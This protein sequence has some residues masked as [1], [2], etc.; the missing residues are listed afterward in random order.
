MAQLVLAP[1]A[2]NGAHICLDP[3]GLG[4]VSRLRELDLTPCFEHLASSALLFV[5]CLFAGVRIIQLSKREK[6]IDTG[7]GRKLLRGKLVGVVPLV[8]LACASLVL[9]LVRHWPIATSALLLHASVTFVAY[10]LLGFLTH[11]NHTRTRRSSTILLTLW[12]LHLLEQLVALRTQVLLGLSHDALFGIHCAL[13]GAGIISW[14]LECFCP[15]RAKQDLDAEPEEKELPY[16][17][18]NVYSR[19]TFGWMTPLMKLGYSRYI[20]EKD[21][22]SLSPDDTARALSDKL[23]QHWSQQLH[24]RNPSLWAALLRAYGGSYSIAAL[25]KIVRDVLSFTEPQLLR[26]FL[27]FIAQYQAGQVQSA[28]R[29]WAIATAM[30]VV[31]VTQTAMLH[32]YFQICFVTGMRV[33]AGLV[34]AI[35][36]KALAQAPDSQGARGDVVNLMSVDATRLQDLCTY[37]LIA[38]S[39]PLQIV[40]AFISLYNLLGW[41][42]FVG[43][44]IM[45]VSLPLNTFIARV[46]K[47]MQGKQMKNRD[48]RTRLMSELLNN[49]K[50]IKLYAWEDSFIRRILTVRNEQ[51]LKMLR[52]IGVTTAVSTTLWTGVPLLVAFGSFATAAYT[53]SKPLT[54]DVI[55]PCISLFNLLQFPLA[56]FASITSQ[57]VEASVAVTRIRKFL[58]SEELQTDARIV[59]EGEVAEGDVVIEIK[60]GDF[61]WSKT[62]LEPTLQ[63]VD[64]TVRKGELVGVL[65]RVGCGKTSLL[66]AVVGE[67]IREE[68]SVKVNGKIAY[69]PQNAWI[70][71]AT[72]RENI[73]FSHRYDEEYYNLVLNACALRPDLALFN[74]GDLTEVGEKGITLS[75]GQRARISLARTVY[76][77]ADLYLLDDPLAAVD[78]H[79]ARHVFDQVIGPN[80]LLAGKA[81]LHVTNSVAYLDQHDSIMMIRRGIILESGTFAEIIADPSKE[82]AK[83]IANH[84]KGA[85]AGGSRTQS[86]TATPIVPNDQQSTSASDTTIAPSPTSIKDKALVKSQRRPSILSIRSQQRLRAQLQ[87]QS[88]GE[89]KMEHREQGNV[90]MSVYKRYFQAS[91]APGV[92]AYLLCMVGQQ[93]CA[94][95]SNVALKMWGNHNQETRDNSSVGYYLFVYGMFALASAVFAFVA[96]VLLWVFCAIKSARSLHDAMLLAVVR[97]PLSFFEQTPMGRIMNLFS[98]DQYVIDEVLIRVFSGFL[99]TMLIVS[100]I[101]AVV[102]GTFPFFLVTLIPLG[103]VYRV[104]MLYY[105]ATSRELKRLDAVSK[106]PIFAWFQESLGG[107]S[108]IRAF[109]QQKVFMTQNEAKLDRNQMVYLP[110]VSVNRWLAVRLELLG[111][112]IVLSAAI[113]SLVALV[114]TGVDAGLVGLVLS[115][116]LSTTQSLNWVVRSASEVE[117]NLVSVERV[118]NYINLEPEAPLEIPDAPLPQNWP[119]NGG[120]VFKD[121]C[122][123]YRPE[124]PLVLN[125]LNMYICSGENIGVVG[126][127]GAGKSSLFLSLLRI[128]EP[129]SGT[130]YI[131]GVDI[132]KIGLHDLRRAISII[133]QEPQLF[134]GTIRENVDP[135]E[136]HDDGKIW[137]ALEQAHLKE[138]VLT[139]PGG[140]DAI[141]KESGSSMS[142]GQRQLVCFARALL[143]NTKILILDEATSAVDL[144]TDKA[145]QEIIRGPLFKGVTTL[146]IAHRLHTVI[147]SDRILVLEAGKIAE[148]DTPA[149]LLKN[150]SSL[151]YALAAEA[152]VLPKSS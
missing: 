31:S 24:S 143:R 35:Y 32:Q 1:L 9:Q 45:I 128:L 27:A 22:S 102:G 62:A 125:N 151:F 107:L 23:Q 57:L 82:L 20:T 51:E 148:L 12:P 146:T 42:A 114:T 110:A 138:Y 71:N 101:V 2:G 84:K 93:A 120:I 129:A 37:G 54:A 16:E 134:E 83:L 126:R 68:G 87:A 100:G 33:R 99:R 36:N 103:Y 10:V 105:L 18:A 4:P 94:I 106:S 56:M 98:R 147:E 6:R 132:T 15:D 142:S 135:T 127:T 40:L 11:L 49:I 131:D 13:F 86:G 150:E 119:R 104:I 133:P 115:Y 44:A 19:L 65:G 81:R 121:Y 76:A 7:G 48:K 149:E 43:V 88:G 96:S 78:A 141:V 69:A 124:L 118:V 53:G 123:R 5:F 28:F 58:L 14:S 74:D 140:L 60:K 95:L 64:L 89:Q 113:F 38:F 90:K 70:M 52:K 34:T 108:T 25:I 77:R 137:A 47:D 109:G 139:L 130:I 75:G 112:C 30:L 66:S 117:Q 8:A 63:H 50:S 152:G 80:G 136:E 59:D 144:E 39:G 55:F 73:L 41:P 46:L 122:M 26:F 97:A 92:V 61:K 79:V 3:E 145:I 29:G 116:G 21:M 91:S 72:I 67:M 17:R 85:S 111:A